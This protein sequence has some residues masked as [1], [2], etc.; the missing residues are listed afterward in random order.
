MVAEGLAGDELN[1]GA[2]SLTECGDS[3]RQDDPGS[4]LLATRR[5]KRHITRGIQDGREKLEQIGRDLLWRGDLAGAVV[6]LK[7]AVLKTG[8][9]SAFRLLC[10]CLTKK[11]DWASV[12]YY[13]DQAM[14]PN[15][16][17]RE[18]LKQ[19]CLFEM[20]QRRGCARVCLAA[21]ETGQLRRQLLDLA[22]EDLMVVITQHPSDLGTRRALGHI[23][24]LKEQ[25]TT[26]VGDTGKVRVGLARLQDMDA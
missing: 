7:E 23:A 14:D 26:L 6:S 19:D 12:C 3:P 9:G 16:P 10:T 17:Y 21:T 15:E 4:E 25:D 8:T 11:Q 2:W 13:A 24:F 1:D 20:Q 22:E 18:L 5:S